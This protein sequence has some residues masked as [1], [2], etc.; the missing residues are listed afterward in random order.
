MNGETMVVSKVS[1]GEMHRTKRIKMDDLS[2]KPRPTFHLPPTI[3]QSSN[4][5]SRE[6]LRRK[7]G[8]PEMPR[9][10]NKEKSRLN[11]D[12]M[13]ARAAQ[14]ATADASSLGNAL[15]Q[16]QTSSSASSRSEEFPSSSALW[17]S[18]SSDTNYDASARLSL[19]IWMAQNVRHSRD[20][21]L[22]LKGP[23]LSEDGDIDLSN[24]STTKPSTMRSI[25]TARTM[26]NGKSRK[27]ESRGG[28]AVREINGERSIPYM[29]SPNYRAS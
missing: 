20:S 21:K 28:K 5:P 3:H 16:R 9:K 19:R 2:V 17:H 12:M 1:R 18:P 29:I 26:F 7:T 15:S 13:A 10:N 22:Q 24:S 25:S 27:E 8:T 23:P 6:R 4:N 11:H 14:V